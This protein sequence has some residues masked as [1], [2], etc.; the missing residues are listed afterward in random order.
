MSTES[1][2]WS[3]TPDTHGQLGESRLRLPDVVAQSFGFMGPVFGVA[4]LIRSLLVPERP[5]KAR[6]SPLR[7]RNHRCTRN[8]CAGERDR[9][10]CATYPRLRSSL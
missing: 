7:S 2:A 5:V 8:P 6:E 10:L 3:G 4:F 1:N 9:T